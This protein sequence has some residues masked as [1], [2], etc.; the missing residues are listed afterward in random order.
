MRD[1]SKSTFLTKIIHR[2]KRKNFANVQISGLSEMGDFAQGSG[3]IQLKATL[4]RRLTEECFSIIME[5]D[6]Y[7]RLPKQ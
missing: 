4:G 3:M 7:V 2:N 6:Q 1:F 5:M